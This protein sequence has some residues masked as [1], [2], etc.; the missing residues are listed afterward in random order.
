VNKKR[1]AED[2]ALLKEFDLTSTAP[3]GGMTPGLEADLRYRQEKDL[4]EDILGD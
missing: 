3:F 1:R 2:I 4:P